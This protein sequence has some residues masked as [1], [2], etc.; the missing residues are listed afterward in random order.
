MSALKRQVRAL[1]AGRVE[2]T[3]RRE[4]SLAQLEAALQ[5]APEAT[6]AAPTAT[7]TS[8]I[9]QASSPTPTLPS[10]ESSVD[11]YEDD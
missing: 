9:W 5:Q 1:A 8:F 10:D 3:A 2:V 4:A 11:G 7:G 6:E